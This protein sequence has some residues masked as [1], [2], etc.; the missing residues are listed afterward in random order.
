MLRQ[1]LDAANET[2]E[3]MTADHENELR[4]AQNEVKMLKLQSRKEQLGQ[5]KSPMRGQVARTENNS[6]DLSRMNDQSRFGAQSQMNTARQKSNIGQG[7][8]QSM[9]SLVSGGRASRPTTP[10]PAQENQ[11]RIPGRLDLAK[12]IEL[13]KENPQIDRPQVVEIEFAL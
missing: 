9:I 1:Q 5:S 4:Q 11:R 3:K 2:I 12:L 7:A 8:D 10:P 13:Y 6:I